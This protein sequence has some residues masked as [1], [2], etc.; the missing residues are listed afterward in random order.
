MG[1]ISRSNKLGILKEAQGSKW[2]SYDQ[3]KSCW[4]GASRND[5]E[6]R[7]TQILRKTHKT[8][9]FVIVKEGIC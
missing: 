5:K 8:K 3:V 1:L 6:N 2:W 9:E 4:I 7:I